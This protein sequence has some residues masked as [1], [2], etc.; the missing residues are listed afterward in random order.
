MKPDPSPEDEEWDFAKARAKLA[1]KLDTR[2]AARK[3]R[4]RLLADA[5]DGRSLRATGRNQ[6][7]NFKASQRIKDLIAKH[8]P[9]GKVS[10]WLEGAI[11]DKLR[12]EGWQALS[13]WDNVQLVADVPSRI[14]LTNKRYAT[15]GINIYPSAGGE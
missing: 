6:H 10:L 7:L 13:G 14:G 11:L 8:V 15:V 1:P 9:K 4:K 5:V 12:S 3:A 2:T